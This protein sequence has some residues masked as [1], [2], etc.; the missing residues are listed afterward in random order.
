MSTN[1]VIPK[2]GLAMEEGKIV[3]WLK[4]EM[5]SVTEG[6]PLFVVES[7]K[8][9]MEIESTDTGILRKILVKE[10]DSAPIYTPIAIVTAPKEVWNDSVESG[11]AT[12]SKGDNVESADGNVAESSMEVSN[13][14]ASPV[15]K[16]IAKELNVDLSKIIPSKGNMISGDDVK[17]YAENS[18]NAVNVPENEPTKSEETAECVQRLIPFTGMRRVVADRMCQSQQTNAQTEHRISVDMTEIVRLRNLLKEEG[19]KVSYNDILSFVVC[20]ALLDFPQMN[21]EFTADGIIEKYYVNLSIAVAV[22]YGLLVPVVK[23]A[24]KMSL[25][26]LSVAIRGKSEG[27]RNGRLRPDDYQGGTFTISNLGMLGLDDFVAIINIPQAGILAVGAVKDTPVAENSEIKIKP[28]M[29]ITLSYDHRV[30]DG[31]LA[32][33]FLIRVKKLMECPFL[34]L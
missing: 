1:I 30:V 32:A 17:A 2:L 24:H 29:N 8:L 33:Q 16:K 12:E 34:L 13:Y 21:S 9:E 23:A 26:E 7:D 5:D 3:K 4:K 27:A 6:E 20:R 31:A 22:D 19:K 14:K 25:S 10:G 11:I 28:M 15:A 18:K